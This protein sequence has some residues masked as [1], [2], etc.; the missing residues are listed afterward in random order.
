MS[1]PPNPDGIRRHTAFLEL[2]PADRPLLGCWLRGYHIHQH[3]PHV[4]SALPTGRLKP[5]DVR[6]DLFLKD[7]AAL[8]EDFS[9]LSDDYSYIG[10]A[11]YGIPWMEAIMGCPVNFAGETIWADPAVEDWSRWT[12]ARPGLSNMWAA[13]LLELLEALVHFAAGRF[14]VGPTLMRGPT[15]M[16]AAMRGT[17][18]LPLDAYDYPEELAR[19][20]EICADVWIEVGQAQLQRLPPSSHGY[21]SGCS[22]LRLWAPQPAIWL[23]EDALAVLS[24]RLYTQFFQALD[25]RIAR[26]FPRVG[27]HLHPTAMWALD[28]VA[29]MDNVHVVQMNYDVGGPSLQ[30]VA[31]GWQTIIGRKPLVTGGEFTPEIL[32]WVLSQLPARG[33]SLQ[34]VAVDAVR[35]EQILRQVEEHYSQRPPH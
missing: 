5:E 15:D 1:R 3:Y 7:C 27:F 21:G 12:W 24:P 13:K 11:F 26:A 32:T 17:V 28:M 18:N 8:Y 31:A 2:E 14:Y 33:V 10:G 19:A 22:G 30:E 35:A 25:Q 6:T 29:R 20:A 34:T 9:A 16:L 23:Q 4:L